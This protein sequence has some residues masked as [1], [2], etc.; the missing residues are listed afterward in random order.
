MH[1]ITLQVPKHLDDDDNFS[2]L[3]VS[4]TADFQTDE[5]VCLYFSMHVLSF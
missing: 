5:G 4:E 3:C 1:G 2:L